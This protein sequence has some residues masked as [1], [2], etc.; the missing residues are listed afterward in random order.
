MSSWDKAKSNVS[1]NLSKEASDNIFNLD[2]KALGATRDSWMASPRL[3]INR[4]VKGMKKV[5]EDTP[6]DYRNMM[7]GLVKSKYKSPSIDLKSFGKSL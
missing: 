3:K 4:S 2:Y 1:R 5:I 7:L 6:I